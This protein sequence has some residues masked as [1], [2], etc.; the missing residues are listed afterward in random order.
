MKPKVIETDAEHKAAPSYVETLTEAA[1]GS[2]NEADLELWS[3]LIGKLEEEHFP[4]KAPDGTG[5]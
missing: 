4:I 3:I 2:R 5:T 1:P